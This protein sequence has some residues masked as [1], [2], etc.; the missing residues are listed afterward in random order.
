MISA[1]GITFRRWG[2]MCDPALT[3]LI[4]ETIGNDWIRHAD[5]LKKLEDKKDDPDFLQ[6]ILAVKQEN[7]QNY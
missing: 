7:K 3:S 5:D 6:K 4:N 1:N 2:V